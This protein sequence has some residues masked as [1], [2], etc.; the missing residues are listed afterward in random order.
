MEKDLEEKSAGFK[1]SNSIIARLIRLVWEILKW[2]YWRHYF[3]Y[4]YNKAAIENCWHF[5]YNHLIPDKTKEIALF[6]ISDIA[7]IIIIIAKQT[8]IR[9]AGV[10]DDVEGLKFAGYRTSHFIELKGYQ[11][12]VLISYTLNIE[13]KMKKLR[14]LGIKE[15]N[16][17]LM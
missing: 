4:R 2:V 14:R 5:F 16:I 10:Y 9:I 13:E 11:G 17:L 8:G 15:E 6:G 1:R 7:K 12:K 3:I